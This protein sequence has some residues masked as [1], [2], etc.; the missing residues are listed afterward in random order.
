MSKMYLFTIRLVLLSLFT[1][2]A[3]EQWPYNRYYSTESQGEAVMLAKTE[4]EFQQGPQN[5]FTQWLRDMTHGNRIGQLQEILDINS[6]PLDASL[7]DIFTAIKT[8][9]AGGA[10]TFAS[11]PSAAP[12]HQTATEL[13][14]HLSF[15][16]DPRCTADKFKWWYRTYDGSCNWL[17]AGEVSEGEYGMA[18]SRDYDQHYYA[19]GISKPREGPNPRAVSNAFF[20]RKDTIYYEHTPLLLGLVEFIMHDITWSPDSTS[21]Y[22]DVTMPEDEEHYYPNTTFRVWRTEAVPGTGT[23]R[24]NP[25]QNVNRATTWLDLSVLYGSTREVARALRTLKKGKL[26]AQEVQARGNKKKAAYLPFN[27]VN[28]PTRSRPGVDEKALFAGGD[29]RTNEDWIMLAVHTLFLREHN[30]LCD[31]L[32][33][34]HPDYDDEQLYQTVRL[35]LSA[36]FSLIGNAY[37]MAYF[38]DMPWPNDDGFSLY[39][40][41]SG[42]DWLEINPANSYPWPVASKAGKPTVVS[43]EMAVV[44]R[45]HEFIINSFPIKDALNTTLWDQDLFSTGFDA[46]GFLDAGLE[47]ILRGVV[48][49]F[50]PNFK[51]GV[52]ESFRSAGKYRGSPFDIVTWSIVHEREQGLPPFNAYFR[53][54]NAQK[55]KVIVPIRA[56]FEDFSTDPKMVA[57]LKRLYKTPDDVDLV[58]GCQLDETLFPHATIPT[59]SLIISL[60]SLISM[61]NSDRFSIG[62]AAMRCWLVD[63][64]WDCHPSNALEELLRKPMP[65][66]EFPNFRFYDTFWMNELDFPAHGQN[67]IWRLVTENTEIKCLQKNPLFPADPEN[68]PVLCALPPPGV[69]IKLLASTA[70]EVGLKLFAQYRARILPTLA[71]LAI[72]VFLFRKVRKA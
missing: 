30:R 59:S 24:E 10:A 71:A 14:G 41:M 45:F 23:S 46:Q 57:E 34:K 9:E 65:R 13:F 36:K 67:L 19:D 12:S 22:I 53:A 64:P 15:P 61:G 52:D 7:H 38:K 58:V 47:N 4:P 68:N 37:Q 28:V 35:L 49:T 44:Y 29:P 17:K 18:K 56:K 1:P 32:A 66:P 60:F 26:L 27:T 50:I 70:V 55:P 5:G 6:I 3:P 31:I 25:R 42:K 54:Y 16:L 43:A 40:E 62:F 63:K 69:D 48:S 72:G 11:I 51:S 8:P 33:A 39:R 20:K 21:E 2:G